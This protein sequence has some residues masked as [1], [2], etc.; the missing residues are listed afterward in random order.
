MAQLAEDFL[1]ELGFVTDCV[2]GACSHLRR[3]LWVLGRRAVLCL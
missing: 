1:E 3:V 2:F